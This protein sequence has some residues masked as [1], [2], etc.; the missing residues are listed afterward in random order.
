MQQFSRRPLRPSLV[1]AAVAALAAT[2]AVTAG[3]SNDQDDDRYVNCV[4]E[5]GQIVDPDLCD[6]VDDD[7][8][9]HSP[10]YFYPSHKRYKVGS[11]APSDW[12]SSR[13][14]PSD[15]SAR[16]RAGLPSSGRIA[17]TTVRSGGFGGSGTGSTG[18]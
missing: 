1:V 11:K 2:G 16:T 5:N 3:C 8:L 18:G 7:G 13:V 10:Y 15:P 6:D 9:Y 12:H 17:G 4:D 14:D